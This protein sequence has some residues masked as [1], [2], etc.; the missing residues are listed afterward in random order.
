MFKAVCNATADVRAA[1][2][3]GWFCLLSCAAQLIHAAML[4][5][6]GRLGLVVQHAHP[7]APATGII[8][9]LLTIVFIGISSSD[10]SLVMSHRC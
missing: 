1:V 8:I 6:R 7:S 4:S 10:E 9:F 2:L 5:G 3:G